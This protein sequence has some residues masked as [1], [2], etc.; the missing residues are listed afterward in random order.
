MNFTEEKQYKVILTATDAAQ[1]A[2][3][4]ERNIIYDNTPPAVSIDPVRTPTNN[5]QQSVAGTREAGS[6]VAVVCPPASVSVVS[7]PTDTTWQ[8]IVAD[9]KEGENIITATATDLASNTSG[10]VS[11]VIVL[12]TQTPDTNITDGPS[13]VS[14]SNMASFGFVSTESGTSF[15][16]SLDYADYTACSSLVQI[17][18]LADGTHNFR[19]L[20]IDQAGNQDTTPAIALWK[21]DPRLRLR[22]FWGRP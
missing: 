17:T 1:N 9:M 14:N 11:A 18:G 2:S 21:I 3:T 4:V 10:S 8:V 19:V 20:A 7:Y 15:E 6:S 12:D 16:C 22:S 13:A 5:R